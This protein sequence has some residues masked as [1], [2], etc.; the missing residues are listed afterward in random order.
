MSQNKFSDNTFSTDSEIWWFLEL[1][2]ADSQ[3]VNGTNADHC[4]YFMIQSWKSLR[5]QPSLPQIFFVQFR[6]VPS[7]IDI[8]AREGEQNTLDEHEQNFVI[9][10]KETESQIF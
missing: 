2:S 9:S 1:F 3:N 4:R 6:S 7:C 10:G 8:A 5:L